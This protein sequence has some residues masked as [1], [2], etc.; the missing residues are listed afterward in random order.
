MRLHTGAVASARPR[1]GGL[2]FG[3]RLLL[4]I[5]GVS[6]TASACSDLLSPRNPVS[7]WD[8]RVH[9]EVLCPDTLPDNWTY[10][11]DLSPSEWSQVEQAIWGLIG[12]G[13]TCASAGN[14]LYS[15]LWG[16]KVKKIGHTDP[17]VRGQ[18]S[19]GSHDVIGLTDWAFE[20]FG[21]RS[22]LA[23]EEGHH[24]GMSPHESVY[25]FGDSCA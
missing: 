12:M 9:L 10:C 14:A 22:V 16:G 24:L 23:H 7:K 19:V 25:A 5:L 20:S 21:L 2:R 13:G 1:W 3:W 15:E 18:G 17:D 4:G 11:N 8:G 6:L